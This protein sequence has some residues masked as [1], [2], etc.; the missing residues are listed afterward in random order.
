MSGNCEVADLSLER[1]SKRA[2][3]VRDAYTH[4]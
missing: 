3:L 2:A 1:Q 4:E